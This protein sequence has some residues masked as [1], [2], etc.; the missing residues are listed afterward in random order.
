MAWGEV[1]VLPITALPNLVSTMFFNGT[2]EAA[3]AFNEPLLKLDAIM[4]T[5]GVIPYPVSNTS[6]NPKAPPGKRYL[7]SG[8][9]IVHPFDLK[10]VEEVS[11]MFHKA[12]APEGN[13]EMKAASMVT[14]ELI[15]R[16]KVSSV[17]TA[18]TAFA[19]RDGQAM[20]MIINMTGQSPEKDDEA[21]HICSNLKDF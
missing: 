4:N 1:V 9:N 18:T 6:P 5:T 21:K 2:K 19:G 3:Q 17:D 7:F 14:F 8:A 15:S 20:N 16:G 11:D 10:M 13:H 12:L